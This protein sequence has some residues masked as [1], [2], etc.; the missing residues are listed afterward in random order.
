MTREELKQR[1]VALALTQVQL[2]DALGVRGSTVTNWEQGLHAVPEWV[3]AKIEE[4]EAQ[5]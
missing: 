2:A 5:K 3:P 4:L 1:R